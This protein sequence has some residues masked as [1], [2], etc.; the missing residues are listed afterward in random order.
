MNQC[1]NIVN[2]TL[3]NKLQWN[4]N[5][6]LY[7]FIEEY[8]FENVVRKL[9]AIL[10]QPQWVKHYIYYSNGQDIYIIWTHK[11]HLILMVSCQK[12]PTRHAYAWQIGPFWQDTLDTSPLLIN[13]EVFILS[14]WRTW[15]HCNT[16][17]YF[18]FDHSQAVTKNGVIQNEYNKPGIE[19]SETVKMHSSILQWQSSF[20]KHFL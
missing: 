17:S 7:I 10:S 3:G 12:G 8:A 15:P 18:Y 2:Q 1:W 16:K 13:H 19:T 11:R 14:I 5:W 4:L 6:N 9:A 20:K